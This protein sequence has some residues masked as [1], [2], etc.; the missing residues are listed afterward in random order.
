MSLYIDRYIFRA[1]LTP[2]YTPDDPHPAT[3]VCIL[4]APRA[5]KDHPRLADVR[6]EGP[7]P[8][9]VLGLRREGGL[10]IMY[11]LC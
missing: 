4:S 1:S 9:W 7:A 10:Q 11:C 6:A 5:V 8:G 3:A 2:P